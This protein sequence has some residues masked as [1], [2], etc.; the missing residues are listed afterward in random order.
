[1]KKYI[2][3]NDVNFYTINAT[4]VRMEI[5]LGRRTNMICRPLSLSC[6]TS[7]LTKMPKST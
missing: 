1:M 2:S 7:F 4:K 6:P 3:E 5:G